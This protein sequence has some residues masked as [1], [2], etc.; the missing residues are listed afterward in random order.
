MTTKEQKALKLLQQAGSMV[1]QANTLLD[2]SMVGDVHMRAIIANLHITI[3]KVQK[4]HNIDQ[5]ITY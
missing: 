5:P 2:C 4:Q 3:G 1:T